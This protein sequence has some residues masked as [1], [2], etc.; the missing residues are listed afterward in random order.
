[1]NDIADVLSR[2]P[3][4]SSQEAA[5]ALRAGGVLSTVRENEVSGL[6]E[7]Y[8]FRLDHLRSKPGPHAAKL[9][10]QVAEMLENL[11]DASSVQTTIVEGPGEHLYYIFL[12]DAGSKVLGCV[13]GINKL[14][15]SDDRWEDLWQGTV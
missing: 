13:S 1:M 5:Q 14:K 12:T 4:P 3:L 11:K 9:A 8:R 10:A 7:I 2:S 15:V 6:L